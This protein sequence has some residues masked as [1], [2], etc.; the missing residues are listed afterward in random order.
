[1]RHTT[2]ARSV[3]AA[4]AAVAL[5][6]TACGGGGG[7]D[8]NTP[9]GEEVDGS[10][11]DGGD[12]DGGDATGEVPDAPDDGVTADSITVGWMGDLTG[13]T[14]S[15]QALNLRG[16]EAYFEKVNAEGGV[17]GRNLRV[18]AKDDEYGAESGVA[19]FQALAN[20][21]RV[22]GI[23]QVGGAHIQEAIVADAERMGLPL[24]SVAQTIDSGTESDFI[25]NTIAHYG[26]QAD[27]AVARM[28]DRVGSAEDLKVAVVQLEVPSG[29]EWNA[30]IKQEVEEVGGTYL[31]RQTIN[32]ASADLGPIVTNLRQ[33]VDNEGLNYIALHAAPAQAL[34]VVNSLAGADLQIPVIGIQGIASLNVFQ[35]GD[36]AQLDV[37]E[38]IHSFLTFADDSEGSAEIREFIE[39]EGS[40][41][42]ADAA[43]INFTH[44][45]LGGMIIHQAIERAAETGEVT[46]ASF[47]DALKGPYDVKGLTCDLDW[48]EINFNPCAAP[49][50]S[51]DG[52]SMQIEGSF[53]QWAEH[54]DGEYGV[55]AG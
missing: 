25:F 12:G 40:S 22:L 42:A 28:I 1:M 4:L 47:H 3:A 36:R 9:A 31:G 53:A 2:R 37:T 41:F 15:A 14:A 48:T 23:T 44:G 35:E 17:L 29:D 24:V 30:Y 50:A 16:L 10:E 26:D 51:S 6:A 38:G 39:G 34:L 5:V 27:V 20:D 45:W 19:N 52:V 43:H 8:G 11:D 33:M 54:I 13:P 55:A 18:V 46:R 32:P 21:D 7:D 49:F